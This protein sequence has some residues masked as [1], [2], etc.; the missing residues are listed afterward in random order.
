MEETKRARAKTAQTIALAIGSGVAIMWIAILVITGGGS[1]AGAAESP[2]SLEVALG[3]WAVIAAG[4]AAGLVFFRKR[5]T[6]PITRS[7]KRGRGG[8]STEETGQVQTNLVIALALAEAPALLAAVLFFLVEAYP[9]M[10]APLAV[11]LLEYVY[12]FPRAEWFGER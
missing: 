7:R 11:F 2:L 1:A 4:T 12:V 3:I 9:L 6:A 8:I 10:W 5:A